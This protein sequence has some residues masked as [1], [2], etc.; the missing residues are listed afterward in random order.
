LASDPKNG[1]TGRGGLLASERPKASS[2]EAAGEASPRPPADFSND[3]IKNHTSPSWPAGAPECLRL[4]SDGS[5]QLEITHKINTIAQQIIHDQALDG[6]LWYLAGSLLN[7]ILNISAKYQTPLEFE[8]DI[9]IRAVLHGWSA[10]AERYYLDPGWLWL[11]HLDEALYSNLGIPERLAIMRMMRIQ[12]Q[13]QA[14]PYLTPALPLPGFMRPRPAQQHIEHDPLVEH[15]VWPGVRE[16]VLFAPRK[17]ATNKF[18][19]NF[20]THCRFLWPH[21]PEDVFIRE[22]F[23]GTYSY[24]SD[25]LQRQNSLRC[26]SMRSDFFSVFPELKQDIPSFD[27]SP[28]LSQILVPSPSSSSIGT[29]KL[30][31]YGYNQSEHEGEIPSFL[32]PESL[33]SFYVGQWSE[34]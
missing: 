1:Q 32:Y 4:V 14:R 9:P 13:T 7:Y 31:S 18:M 5:A 12:Y 16:H 20:R 28:G 3:E 22:A 11:R 15:F 17:Y 6:R 10:V 27:A 8:E 34:I 24:S 26:W 21:N 30:P 33:D 29:C 25:F 23:T 2:L 19:D